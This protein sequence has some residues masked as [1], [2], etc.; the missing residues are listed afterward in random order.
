MAKRDR[1]AG[2]A[3]QCIGCYDRAPMPPIWFNED[4]QRAETRP[5]PRPGCGREYPVRRHRYQTLRLIGWPLYRVASVV[6]WAWAQAGVHPR[7]RRG[8]VDTP[9]PDCRRSEIIRRGDG[10]VRLS[11]AMLRRR[12][13]PSFLRGSSRFT[14]ASECVRPAA[15]QDQRVDPA[16]A[17]PGCIARRSSTPVHPIRQ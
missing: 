8:R 2:T 10:R 14:P 12:S 6:S 7:A 11:S 1:R 4:G 9:D 17:L 13:A 16:L 3:C 5:C 15:G